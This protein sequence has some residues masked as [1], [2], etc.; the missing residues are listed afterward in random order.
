MTTINI[1][2][3][4]SSTTGIS[5]EWRDAASKHQNC[6]TKPTGSLGYL[7]D[8]AVRLCSM[9]G[10]VPH[11]DNV[12]IS[13]FAADHGVAEE[14]VSAFQQVVTGE[15]V[16]NFAN[17]GAA[18]CILADIIRAK[19]E[20]VNLG[21]VNNLGVLLGVIDA[22]IAPGTYNFSQR[23]A[24]D[25]DQLLQALHEGRNAVHRAIKNKVSLFIGGD[26]GIGNTTSATALSCAYTGITARELVGPGTG[27][28][29][30]GVLHKLEVID[31]ALSLHKGTAFN[32]PLEI[33]RS[34]GGFEIAG[35]VGAYITCAQE[36]V[37]MLVDGFIATSAALAAYTI[38]PGVIDWM[39]LSHVSA[40]PGHRKL[41]EFLGLKPI[42]DLEMR[43][44]EGSGA[45]V[46][47]PLIRMACQLHNDMATFEEAGISES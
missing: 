27:L 1:E 3:I 47:V 18:I 31:K 42:V 15:M 34:L 38:N 20:V 4:Y 44:G 2:W 16:K 28:D 22:P 29:A 13:I 40:E 17:G 8:I 32:N 14:G 41:I 37:P 11:I 25:N 30:N 43:L 23:T 21:T 12:Y 9:L 33:L 10:D 36:G 26:M 5:Q 45:A 6:L 19:M 39:I 35:L 7:E 24:M 46:T